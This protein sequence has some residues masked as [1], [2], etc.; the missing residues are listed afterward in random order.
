MQTCAPDSGFFLLLLSDPTQRGDFTADGSTLE[1]SKYYSAPAAVGGH[2][3]A[4]GTLVRQAWPMEI[5]WAP[6]THFI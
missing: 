4:P 3:P 2:R 1:L 5:F 6:S